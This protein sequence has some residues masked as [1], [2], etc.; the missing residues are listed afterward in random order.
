[1]PIDRS[2]RTPAACFALGVTVVANAVLFGVM[3]F[4]QRPAEKPAP[5]L[6]RRDLNVAVVKKSLPKPLLPQ[7]KRQAVHRPE[8]KERLRV[9]RSPRRRP[10]PKRA[11]PLRQAAIASV[12][13]L[14]EL[15]PLVAVEPELAVPSAL[16]PAPPDP[17]PGVN[18]SSAVS[19]QGTP[20]RDS[21]TPGEVDQI[22]ERTVYVPAV[23]PPA[24][25]RRGLSGWVSLTFVVTREGRVTDVAVEDSEGGRRFEEPAARAVRQWRFRPGRLN[26]EAVPVLCT[27]KINFRLEE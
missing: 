6:V 16:A 19:E 9:A 8:P 23:Y 15:Q 17:T 12:P 10:A 3:A 20:A 27:V 4:L 1:M 26:G 22:P 21:Y 11:A 25:L 14:T 2:D 18:E 24:A 5:R 7:P 13:R